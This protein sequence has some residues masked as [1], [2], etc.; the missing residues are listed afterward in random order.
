M[1]NE[2]QEL[3]LNPGGAQAELMNETPFL[4]LKESESEFE[5]QATQLQVWLAKGGNASEEERQAAGGLHATVPGG[6]KFMSHLCEGKVDTVEPAAKVGTLM[7]AVRAVPVE[8]FSNK[9]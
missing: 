2:W 1:Q 9:T 3:E 5:N 4:P 7:Q 8:S 6:E